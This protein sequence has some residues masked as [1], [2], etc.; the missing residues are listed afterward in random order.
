MPYSAG[1]KGD[2]HGS[3]IKRL[4]SHELF[5]P[6]DLPNSFRGRT[7]AHPD[8]HME[9]VGDGNGAEVGELSLRPGSRYAV[10]DIFF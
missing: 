6:A 10:A 5:W 2:G 1:R 7:V 9:H 8:I 3:K 4:G